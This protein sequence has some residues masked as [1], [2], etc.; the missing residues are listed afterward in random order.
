MFT[1]HHRLGCQPAV[2]KLKKKICYYFRISKHK[3]TFKIIQ[4]LQNSLGLN[5]DILQY[6]LQSQCEMLF[7][8][9]R[10]FTLELGGGRVCDDTSASVGQFVRHEQEIRQRYLQD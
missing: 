2:L 6:I 8:I 9:G 5:F 3:G 7:W 10:I 1:T 4:K